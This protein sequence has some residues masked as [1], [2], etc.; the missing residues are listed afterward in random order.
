MR[1]TITVDGKPVQIE[2]GEPVLDALRD[3][4]VFIPTLCYHESLEGYGACRLCMV[5]IV[6]NKQSRLVTSCSYPAEEGLEVFPNS[7][8]A[9]EIRKKIVELLLARCPNVP[10]IHELASKLE[11]EGSSFKK[12]EDEQCVLCGLCVRV[13][14]EVVGVNAVS[15]AGRGIER[16]VATPFHMASDAC[17]GCGACSYV[18]PTGCIEMVEAPE[19]PGRRTMNMGVLSLGA[20]PNNHQCETC[21]VDDYFFAEM[22]RTVEEFRRA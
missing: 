14:H 6:K 10:V 21:D 9:V 11:V 19:A 8:K 18:C 15:L 2:Q 5:E 16:E 3:L 7:R 12:T 22:K 1:V 17:I 4:D 13:C 20:C